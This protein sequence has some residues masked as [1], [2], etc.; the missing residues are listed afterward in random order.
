MRRTPRRALAA[1]TI[2][3]ALATVAAMAG[4]TGAGSTGSSNGSGTKDTLTL[5]MTA[6]VTTSYFETPRYQG[7]INDALY[8]SVLQCD[9]LGKPQPRA[10]EKWEFNADNT[11]ATVHLRSGMK[12]SDGTAVDSQ[13]V[14]AAVG[15]A[16]PRNKRFA[17]VKVDTPDPLTAVITWPTPQPV[18]ALKLCD[19][20]LTTPKAIAA[21]NFNDN[22]VG[23]GPYTLDT[24]ATTRGSV[25]TL[26][27][28]DS[29]WDSKTYPYKKLVLKVITSSTAALNALKTG[30]IDGSLIGETDYN[31]ATG[32]GL[33]IQ[34]LKGR[35]TRLLLTDHLGQKVPALGNADVRRAMNMVFDKDA[36][37]KNLYQ[38][39]A[40]PAVQIFRPGSTA[41]IDDLKDPYP[42]NV[43]AAK[44]LM[45]KAGYPNGFTLEI[46]FMQGQGLEPLIP[47]VTQQLGL[48]NIKVTQTTLSGPNAIADLLSGKFPVPFWQLGNYGESL[49]DIQDY[50]L[51]DGIW[52]VE[53]QPDAT[54]AKYWSQ[55][56]AGTDQQKADAQK[57]INRYIVDQAWFVPMVYP[58]GFYAYNAKLNVKQSSDFS[59][60]HPLLRDFQ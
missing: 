27:K 11:G 12:F 22:P 34:A 44:A 31:E 40:T 16:E 51:P 50:V 9:A 23:S 26:V 59:A 42:Y 1:S 41:Y 32:S 54:V 24:K 15:Y 37:A 38:G 35:T 53:H 46:P 36:M 28:N 55:I 45:A 56:L 17:G 3:I 25:Y 19:I 8:D 58:E 52:N 4:C 5:G 10:A 29:Y 21:A 43:D 14:K 47:V 2:L 48:L 18:L 20:G 33:K 49:Q 60:L 6:D 57:A 13:A 7:W 39:H 30:Q